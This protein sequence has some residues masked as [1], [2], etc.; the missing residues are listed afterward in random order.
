MKVRVTHRRMRQYENRKGVYAEE[1][2]L[3]FDRG[4]PVYVNKEAWEKFT[5]GSEL[6]VPDQ[7]P[8]GA[9]LGAVVKLAMREQQENPQ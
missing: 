5:F 9:H 1:Y 3:G 7:V 4:N 2:W 6:E 8:F